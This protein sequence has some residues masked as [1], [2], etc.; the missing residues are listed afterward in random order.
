MVPFRQIPRWLVL[1]STLLASAAAAQ[2][3]L[4]SQPK[5]PRIANYDIAVRLDAAAHLLHGRETLHW[6]NTAAAPLSELQFHLYLNG[7]RSSRST[8][9]R[10]AG[11]RRAGKDKRNEWGYIEVDSLT[12]AS[13][14]NWLPLT[15]FI[16]PDDGNADDKSV[17]RLQLPRPL[18]PG[19]SLT[20]HFAFTAQLPAPPIARTGIKN[21]FV[22]AG[23]WFPKIGVYENGAWNCHQFHA[24]SEFYADFGVY[25]VDIT[26]PASH[27]VGAT[28]LCY[29][30]QEHPDGTVTHRYHAEDVH[31]F[32]WTASPDYVVFTGKS[33]DVEIRV[34]MQRDHASQGARFIKAAAT[35]EA[36]F[37]DQYGDYPYPNLTVVDPRRGAMN[38]GGMEYP[39][40]ITAYNAYSMP[41]G[42]HALEMVIMHEFGHNFWYHLVASN[43]FEEAWLDEGINTFSEIGILNDTYGEPGS[44]IDLWGFRLSDT[45][46]QRLGYIADPAID[47]IL[48]PAWS[49]S[50]NSAY[51]AMSYNKPGLALL[52]L[53][54]YLGRETMNRIMRTWFDRWKFKHPHTADFI[55]VAN[56][57]SGQNL[58]WFFDQALHT[59]AVLDYSISAVSSE[60]VKKARGFDYDLQISPG[61][62]KPDSSHSAADSAGLP[63][64]K[65]H[66]PTPNP[67]YQTRVDVRRLGDF[68]FPVEV[69]MVFAGGDTL[70]ERWDGRAR[71]QRFTLTRPTRLISAT[72]DPDHKIP[73][74]IQITNNSRTTEPQG[75]TLNALTARLLFWT[76]ALFDMPQALNLLTVFS[77]NL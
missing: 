21:E 44:M 56:E 5:S 36:W 59:T 42:I 9:M 53:Q 68:I 73:L 6:R 25:N 23:Q 69:Q 7:F 24:N 27:I 16:Q 61:A 60:P 20:L 37:Q 4:F 62:A 35:A 11:A 65:A 10:E 63:A 28:G 64:G 14:E 51:S 22:M 70:R 31:D 66:E 32:A 18:P 75:A 72:V 19:E 76:Q 39:T 77:M 13:G 15:A 50:S 71:W 40:L 2:P 49:F 8:F 74:D 17:L 55:A 45:Q 43:E 52:T 12:S 1:M 58:D 29:A 26:V 34:L 57:I 30:T 47:P 67:P 46:G 48:Q 41:A 54:N 38:A 3:V 33:Q